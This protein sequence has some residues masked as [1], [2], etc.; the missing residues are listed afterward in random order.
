[1]KKKDF[2]I[3][4]AG[5]DDMIA[6]HG[7]AVQGV[8]GSPTSPS[9]S[10]SVGLAAKGLPE[11]IVFGLPPQVAAQFLNELGRRFTTEGVPPLDVDLLDVAQ[12]YPAR[13]VP[14]P[15][16]AADQ[17]LFAAK[18]RYP[19][20]TAVQLVWTDENSRY[21]WDNGFDPALVSRQPI[22]RS[23]LN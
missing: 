3:Y 20:Y 21:P 7:W 14:V 22:L 15:R 11:V 10:Y 9:F 16:V 2:K 5:M 18:H 8:F 12:G 6:K 1:M 13:L 19:A 17:Y 4:E 23:T